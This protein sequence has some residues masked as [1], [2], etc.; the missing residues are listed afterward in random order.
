MLRS[1]WPKFLGCMIW[2][3]FMACSGLFRPV[4]LV[5]VL[6]IFCF[7]VLLLLV[8]SGVQTCV[9][10]RGQVSVLY[11]NSPVRYNISISQVFCLDLG[12]IGSL[13]ILVLKLFSAFPNSGYLGSLRLLSSSNLRGGDKGLLKGILAGSTWNRFLLNHAQGEMLS[14][15]FCCSADSDGHLFWDCATPPLVH[16]CEN[17]EFHGLMNMDD[18]A[19]PRYLLWDGWLPALACPGGGATWASHRLEYAL[20]AYSDGICREWNASD[21]FLSEL[22]DSRT[23]DDPDVWT[24]GS[25]LVDDLSGI[26]AGGKGVYAHQSGSGW[27]DRSLGYLDLRPA[28]AGLNMERCTLL[29]SVPGSLQSVQRSELWCVILALQS[30]SAVHLG[31][32]NLN[33][34]RHVSGILAGRSVRRPFELCVVEDLLTL[35]E[36]II[37]QR[38]TDTVR[39]S[40]VKSHPDDE[41][42]R[43]G[44]VRAVDTVGNDHA[45]RAA[46]LG[47]RRVPEQVIDLC[48]RCISDCTLWYHLVLEL[49]RFFVAIARR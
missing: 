3:G 11:V 18:S 25:Y 31:V 33:V 6:F 42:V 13:A 10:G 47:R 22:A 38:C 2:V 49:H 8:T 21:Q 43:T 28:D 26:G 16:I 30:S 12:E 48:R 5:M 32:D 46:E 39:I 40:N 36:V 37:R 15:R 17:P 20:G 41:M 45:D 1:T 29:V 9:S 23:S 35:I 4:L 14:C 19:W 24:D 7:P 44:R 27:F 34:V